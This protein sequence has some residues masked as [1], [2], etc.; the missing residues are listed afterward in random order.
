MNRVAQ[1]IVNASAPRLYFLSAK[2]VAVIESFMMASGASDRLGHQPVT[3]EPLV[4]ALSNVASGKGMDFGVVNMNGDDSR[5]ADR[6]LMVD[7]FNWARESKHESP[8]TLA[9]RAIG[10]A[11][12]QESELMAVLLNVD[13]PLNNNRAERSLRKIVVGRKHW[14]FYGSDCHAE[15]AAAIFSLIATCRMHGVEP[16]Q[17]FDELMWVLPY[18]PR[19]RH[20]ELAPQNGS[21]Q[22]L[23][24][25]DIASESRLGA[26]QI[27]TRRNCAN[28][29]PVREP[30][31][32]GRRLTV[33]SIQI[34]SNTRRNI[35][36]ASIGLLA[37]GTMST[38]CGLREWEDLAEEAVDSQEIGQNESALTA[39][40]TE[41]AGATMT[42]DE[43]AGT[44]GGRARAR[45]ADPNCVAV[46]QSG[47]TVVY[48]F[49][50]CTGPRGLVSVT[51][52]LTATFSGSPGNIA[53]S[54]SGTGIK[55]NEA[56]IDIQSSGTLVRNGNVR[57][58]TV[59]TKGTGV[60]RRGFDL[61]RDGQ[62]VATH[63]DAT[64]CSKL[65]GQWSLDIGV[66]DRSTSI[67]NFN[68]CDGKCPGAGGKITHKGFG[69][70]QVVISFDGSNRATWEGSN[71]RSGTVN[72]SCTP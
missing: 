32:P 22:Q 62:Y 66:R 39:I 3:A 51:G 8:H 17:Y 57:T 27:L 7:F 30:L 12:D 55:V 53:F 56:T 70:R 69:G 16:Q 40:S 31:D 24:W 5:A 44:A 72:L 42:P 10:Y 29:W 36:F 2:P 20:L 50:N 52:V 58:L 46:A 13:L 34:P 33:M 60:G 1:G 11:L 21:W 65:N 23:D 35:L 49:T 6:P 45:L 64:G 61:D 54:V 18:W 26:D 9:A 19:D 4:Q 41:G 59:T 37:V 15:G 68:R 25:P 48:T 71:G 38:G 43:V 28:D 14:L 67:T 47:A 63:D